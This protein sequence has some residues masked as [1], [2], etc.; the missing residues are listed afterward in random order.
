[1]PCTD[2]LGRRGRLRWGFFSTPLVFLR[3]PKLLGS[4]GPKSSGL[5]AGSGVIVDF[6]NLFK[7]FRKP[8]ERFSSQ[9][10]EGGFP[11]SSL[12][13]CASNSRPERSSVFAENRRKL[14]TIKGRCTAQTLQC[15]C[16]NR[17]PTAISCCNLVHAGYCYIKASKQASKQ[18]SNQ[19]IIQH[20]NFE[21]MQ[22]M[23]WR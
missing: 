12:H 17:L 6:R 20:H 7:G 13:N 1:V 16:V 2:V 5:A 14:K 22:G 21:T 18:S 8:F 4:C 9:P 15:A 19:A 10:N 3:A 11:F 23:F